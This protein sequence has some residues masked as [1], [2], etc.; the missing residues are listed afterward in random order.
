MRYVQPVRCGDGTMISIQANSRAFCAPQSEFGPWTAF[1][2]KVQWGQHVDTLEQY[3]APIHE[4]VVYQYVPRE[5]VCALIE[6]HGGTRCDWEGFEP[7]SV[8]II[9]RADFNEAR[10]AAR[11]L[12]VEEALAALTAIIADGTANREARKRA[13]ERAEW[14]AGIL[15]LA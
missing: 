3:E 2:V 1:D 13:A 4:G 5:L 11:A 9:M 14:V 7:P 8:E 10:D 6:A 15:P 12:G